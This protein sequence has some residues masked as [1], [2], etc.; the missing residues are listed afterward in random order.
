MSPDG[1]SNLLF[2][3]VPSRLRLDAEEKRELR[4]F[5]SELTDRVMGGRGFCCLLTNDR[6]LQQLNREFLDHDY[7]TDVLSFPSAASFSEAGELAISVERADEQARQLGH[8]LLDE[9]RVLMLHGALHLAGMDH[10]QDSGGMARAERK[11]RNAF[12]LPV[13]LIAR[14]GR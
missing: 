8:S 7:P 6:K 2:E 3:A 10:E 12:E 11:W 13:T 14:A 5:A 9:I 4:Q 1:S